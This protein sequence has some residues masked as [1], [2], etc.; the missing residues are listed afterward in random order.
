VRRFSYIDALRG[1]AILMVI[2]VHTSHAFSDLPK[3]LSTI[4]NQDARGVQLFFV[5]LCE[6]GL[7]RS[8]EM[9]PLTT[10]R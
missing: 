10:P 8:K 1:Y 7:D 2:A 4:L 3:P 5:T 9:A 6:Y